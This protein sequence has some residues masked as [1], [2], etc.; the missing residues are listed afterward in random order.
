MNWEQQKIMHYLIFKNNYTLYKLPPDKN[1]STTDFLTKFYLQVK[2][3][4]PHL[5]PQAIKSYVINVCIHLRKERKQLLRKVSISTAYQLRY[6]LFSV[7][8]ETKAAIFDVVT[9]K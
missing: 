9:I 1:L 7:S 4:M 8:P 6:N 3:R 2:D 5:A